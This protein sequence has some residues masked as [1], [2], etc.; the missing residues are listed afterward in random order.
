MEMTP[1]QAFLAYLAGAVAL[2]G[3]IAKITQPYFERRDAKRERI[4][5]RLHS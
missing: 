3:L 2:A 5:R 1:D 4:L